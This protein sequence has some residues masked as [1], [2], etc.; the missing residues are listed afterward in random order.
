MDITLE[1]VKSAT[2]QSK[3][4]KAS[5]INKIPNRFL[6]QVLKVFLPYFKHLFQA[7]INIEYH[8]KEF[9]V[10]VLKKP[11][12][13]NYSLA[14][15]YRLI[16]LLNTLGKALETVFAQHLSNLAEAKNILPLQQMRACRERSMETALKL[17]VELVHTV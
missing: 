12:K 17:L 13:K 3:L 6:K 14:E 16:A 7:C 5:G 15:S 2:Q 1:E 8:P 10:I 9:P 11:R 4:D